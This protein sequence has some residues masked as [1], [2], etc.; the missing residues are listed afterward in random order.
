MVIVDDSVDSA[1]R[2]KYKR[3]RVRYSS[4]V[5]RYVAERIARF[6]FKTKVISLNV[7]KE[8]KKFTLIISKKTSESIYR[9]FIQEWSDVFEVWR[10]E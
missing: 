6:T 5:S 8:S 10:A 1:L 2:K 4:G 3:V 7:N 9:N